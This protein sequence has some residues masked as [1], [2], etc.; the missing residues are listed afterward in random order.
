MVCSVIRAE[1]DFGRL[2]LRLRDSQARSGPESGGV[3]VQECMCDLLHVSLPPVGFV[4]TGGSSRIIADGFGGRCIS[5]RTWTRHD[6]GL[7]W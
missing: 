7:T 2:M 1:N 4:F 3:Y 6:C 5:V